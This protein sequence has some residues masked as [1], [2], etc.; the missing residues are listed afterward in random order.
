MKKWVLI[1]FLASLMNLLYAQEKRTLDVQE[2][3]GIAM[4][5]NVR[6]LTAEN[7]YNSTVAN[8]LPKTWGNN[9]PTISANARWSRADEASQIATSEGFKKSANSYSYSLNA[10]YIVFDGLKKFNG[11]AQARYDET[12]AQFDFE[13]TKQS[14]VLDVYLAYFNVLKNQQLLKISEENLKRSQEQLKRLEERNK[15]GAQILSDV[16]KQKVLVGSDKLALNKAKNNLNTSKASLSNL[17]GIDVNTNVE[18]KE[19]SLEVAFEAD[20][21]NYENAYAQALEQRKDYLAAEK[22]LSSAKASL[23]SSRGGYFPTLNAFATY[24]W[25]DVFLP[26][27]GSNDYRANDRVNMGFN[28]S[29][30]IFNG[31]QTSAGVVQADQSVQTSKTNLENTRRK[32]GLD[33]KIALL[34]LQTSYENVKLS[35]ENVASAKEDLRLATEKYNLGAGTILDQ[36]IANTNYATAEANYIQ[37]VYDFLYAKQQYNLALGDIK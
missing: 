19:I 27:F 5:N 34:N 10:D 30:P 9:L 22:K 37:S 13:N 23:R 26:K 31:F 8:V 18:L 28:L 32:I 25:G 33:V 36:I 16:Y 12:S 17:I 7:T 2:A 20:K 4:K 29:V 1:L 3:I 21:M 35:E 6:V 15:L 14:V 24:S 11:M